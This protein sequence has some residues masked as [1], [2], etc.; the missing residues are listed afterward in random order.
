MIAAILLVVA[1]LLAAATLAHIGP[2]VPLAATVFLVALGALAHL[3]NPP[4][5]SH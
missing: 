5:G 2:A 1:A 3:A 4:A